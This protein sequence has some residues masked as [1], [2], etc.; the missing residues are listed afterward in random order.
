M[1]GNEIK[2]VLT[3]NERPV[4]C[5]NCGYAHP[6]VTMIAKGNPNPFEIRIV[7]EKCGY[8]SEKGETIENLTEK[9]TNDL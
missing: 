2:P 6:S 4:L 7:C 3:Y 1:T 9:W 5:P 8:R